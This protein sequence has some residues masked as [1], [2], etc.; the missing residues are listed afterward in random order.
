MTRD[1]IKCSYTNICSMG[2]QQKQFEVCAQLQSYGLNEVTDTWREEE[3]L[4]PVKEQLDYTEF[5]LGTGDECMGKD[6]RTD[7]HG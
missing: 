4:I 2:K 1:I 6:Q 5:C 7:L 3:A